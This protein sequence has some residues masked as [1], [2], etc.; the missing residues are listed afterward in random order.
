MLKVKLIASEDEKEFEADVNL[1]FRNTSA[2]IVDVQYGT[3]NT[4]Y[5]VLISYEEHKKTQT[6]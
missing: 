3:T 1:F 4:K 5:S 2:K 6:I